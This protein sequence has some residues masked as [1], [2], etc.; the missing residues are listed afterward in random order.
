[1]ALADLDSLSASLN[2]L[3]DE[4]DRLAAALERSLN[5]LRA[6]GTGV[7]SNVL[8]SLRGYRQRH[9]DLVCRFRIDPAPLPD[10]ELASFDDWEN[11]IEAGKRHCRLADFF[12]TLRRVEAC[13]QE[14]P[15]PLASV[16]ADAERL[17]RKISEGDLSLAEELLDGRHPLACFLRLVTR[18][19]ELAD[20]MWTEFQGRVS[21]CY[22]RDL[23]TALLR[24]RIT[25]RKT[26][27]A[28]ES[29]VAP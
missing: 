5:A 17:E 11:A 15:G 7:T 27:S 14:T 24:G 16:L 20:E 10:A 23:S 4:R 2:N 8:Q 3:R 29:E 6:E 26:M 12:E 13:G 1:M 22:G 19:E 28:A 18:G 9:Q 21:D 25:L